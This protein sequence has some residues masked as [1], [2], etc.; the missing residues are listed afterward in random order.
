M[1]LHKTVPFPNLCSYF[2]CSVSWIIWEH[3][4]LQLYYKW[5]HLSQISISMCGS[6]SV[7]WKRERERLN[8]FK[9]FLC[10]WL[11]TL[12]FLRAFNNLSLHLSDDGK[13]DTK[14]WIFLFHGLY[15]YQCIYSL[16]PE[17]IFCPVTK[18]EL[19]LILQLKTNLSLNICFTILFRFSY[20]IWY[21]SQRWHILDF[22]Y[23][24][25]DY[26]I[27]SDLS[28]LNLT[29]TWNF[30]FFWLSQ[31]LWDDFP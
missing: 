29:V 22:C 2:P 3:F 16:P 14:K 11:Q 1:E 8:N 25:S 26:D 20:V 31:F 19:N 9:V 30:I 24:I 17:S 4:F 27:T 10:Q 13:W 23:I 7:F 28:S 6:S 12:I 21:K 5:F 18:I 15:S